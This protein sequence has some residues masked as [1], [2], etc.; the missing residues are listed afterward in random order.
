MKSH[1]KNSVKTYKYIAML[2]V[3]EKFEGKP[4]Y[5]IINNKSKNQIGILSWYK[6][7]K[8]Y[9]FSSQP[10][11]VFNISCLKDVLDFIENII[12]IVEAEIP[13]YNMVDPY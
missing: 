5:R 8:Q 13:L 10:N 9:V 11:C 6:P 3:D 1:H 2:Y 4:V 12:P 7:W